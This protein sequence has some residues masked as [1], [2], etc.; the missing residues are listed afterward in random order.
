VDELNYDT[1]SRQLVQLMRQ[2]IFSGVLKPGDRVVDSY[3]SRTMGVSRAPLREALKELESEG[4]IVTYPRRGTYVVEL[5]DEDISELYSLRA[6]LEGHAVARA[7]DNLDPGSI[8]LL[9]SILKEMQAAADQRDT[10]AVA[11][12]NMRFHMEICKL[13]GHKRL[14]T[15]WRSLLA[16]I[17]MLSALGTELYIEVGEMRKRHEAL[18]EIL[19]KG[20]KR[21]A[22]RAFEEHILEA[23][24][25]LLDSIKE[26]RKDPVQKPN[27]QSLSVRS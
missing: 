3:L 14:L 19:A 18:L 2:Q 26:M 13:S 24:K 4:L 11:S 7:I 21:Q 10:L 1:L 23:K 16:Q 20:N 15:I 5:T 27:H 6:L 9:A 17:R 25:K 22:K 8:E 12:H